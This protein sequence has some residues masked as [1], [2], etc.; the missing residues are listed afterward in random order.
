MNIDMKKSENMQQT[1][2]Y[3]RNIVIPGGNELFILKGDKFYYA[4]R[5]FD[6]SEL[7]R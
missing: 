3:L 2:E 7:W 1:F 5:I 6:K 4:I